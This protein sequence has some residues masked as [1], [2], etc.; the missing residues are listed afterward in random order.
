MRIPRI[1]RAGFSLLEIV[2]AVIILGI[3]VAVVSPSVFRYVEKAKYQEV[4]DDFKAIET[5]MVGYY[6]DV[7]T[8]SPLNDIGGFTTP[9]SGPAYKHM[10]G[11]DGQRGWDGPY[12]QRIKTSSSFGG[13]YDIDVFNSSQASI[14]LGTQSQMGVN[15]ADVLK[16]VNEILDG[17]NDTTR[18]VVWGDSNGIHYGFNY[19]KK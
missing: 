3:L 17:D 4:V 11:G 15:Y 16:N 13:T 14:D 9:Q 6:A 10:L 18:G 7:G 5:A 19:I 8:L 12:L 2:V 1:P